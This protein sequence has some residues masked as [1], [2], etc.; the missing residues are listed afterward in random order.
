MEDGR[1]VVVV[2]VVVVVRVVLPRQGLLRVQVGNH[3]P[4]EM[5]VDGE[6]P[7]QVPRIR[8]LLLIIGSTLERQ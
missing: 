3:Q 6:V 7:P 1:V 5:T 2:V 8:K 4:P